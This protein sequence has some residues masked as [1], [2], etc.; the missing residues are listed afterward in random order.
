MSVTKT[1]PSKSIRLAIWLSH[2]SWK[3]A[4]ILA[5]QQQPPSST[6][7][8]VGWGQAGRQHQQTMPES[9]GQEEF[10]Q[11]LDWTAL[12]EEAGSAPHRAVNSSAEMGPQPGQSQLA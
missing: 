4:R 6:G 10:S 8:G 11:P 7:S 3:A 9:E 5:L 1:A 2:S 12:R